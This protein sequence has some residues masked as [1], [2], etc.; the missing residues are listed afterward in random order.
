M[1]LFIVHC[2]LFIVQ[3]NNQFL[4]SGLAEAGEQELD[5]LDKLDQSD[6]L[7]GLESMS[8]NIFAFK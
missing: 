6:E 1:S 8:I 3:V 2:S 7:D 4:F 5:Q